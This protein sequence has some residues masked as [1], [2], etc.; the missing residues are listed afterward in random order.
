M[1]TLKE[2][3]KMP[4]LRIGDDSINHARGKFAEGTAE[5]EVFENVLLS[6][7][8][9]TLISYLTDIPHG[10]VRDMLTGRKKYTDE[11]YEKICGHI[12]QL[13]E[14]GLDLGIYPCTD[15]AVVQPATDLLLSFMVTENKLNKAITALRNLSV[16]NG[17]V[18]NGS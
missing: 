11:A 2:R 13:I 3:E 18:T 17:D 4:A 8:P 12:N 16:Q 9:Y 5:R 1:K 7:M 10:D 14:R 6:R 15:L